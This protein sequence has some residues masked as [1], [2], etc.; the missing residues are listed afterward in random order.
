M[1]V[2]LGRQRISGAT[3]VR[4]ACT[5]ILQALVEVKS[6]LTGRGVLEFDAQLH[7]VGVVIG[8]GCWKFRTGSLL[9]SILS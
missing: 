4:D 1:K 6:D 7:W 8:H 5:R 3:E 2:A 9:P